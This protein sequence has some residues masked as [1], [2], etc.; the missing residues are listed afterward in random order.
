MDGYFSRL[1]ALD[2]LLLPEPDEI[3]S[4]SL[5][6]SVLGGNFQFS[7]TQQLVSYQLTKKKKTRIK[8]WFT[9]LLSINFLYPLNPTQDHR[10]YRAYTSCHW[11]RGRVHPG[12]SITRPH[13]DKQD[14]QPCTLAP[15]VNLESSINLTCM[16]FG[17][18][19]EARV[20]GEKQRIHGESMQT[21]H[22]KAPAGIRTRRRR[23]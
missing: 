4:K 13:R 20:P 19:G 17:Q 18:R 6:Q 10:G 5:D 11:S 8:T 21:P 12:Q 9:S 2:Q 15:R 16:F 22:K 23:C 3:V 7:L 1:L 14:T